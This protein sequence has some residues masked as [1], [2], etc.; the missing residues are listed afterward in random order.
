MHVP[1]DALRSQKNAATDPLQQSFAALMLTYSEGAAIDMHDQLRKF[2]IQP[3]SVVDYSKKV[4]EPA[5]A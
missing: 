3:T 5:E 4:M 1:E 2:S